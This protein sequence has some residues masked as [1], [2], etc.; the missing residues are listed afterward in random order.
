[1]TIQRHDSVEL[2]RRGRPGPRLIVGLLAVVALALAA[3]VSVAA[4][5]SGPETVV[6]SWSELARGSFEA[7]PDTGAIVSA[8]DFVDAV[9]GSGTNTAVDVIFPGGECLATGPLDFEP[10]GLSGARVSGELTAECFD[11]VQNTSFSADVVVD[12]AWT[13]FGP[14]NRVRFPSDPSDPCRTNLVDRQARAVGFVTVDAPDAGLFI[15][16]SP[17]G[18]GFHHL[19]R[20][21][22][23]CRVAS[24]S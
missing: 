12:V 20:Q 6:R 16:A 21:R 4:D 13:G 23:V 24:S 5:S 8:V 1:M 18:D 22:D 17:L 3:P 10:R 9:E 7:G 11:R 15:N 19:I 2:G 14:A